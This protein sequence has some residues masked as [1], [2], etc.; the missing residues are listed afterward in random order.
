MKNHLPRYLRQPGDEGYRTPTIEDLEKHG[1]FLLSDGD[2]LTPRCPTPPVLSQ[3]RSRCSQT[4][5]S[6]PSPVVSVQM[7][8][9]DGLP[10]KL[11]WKERIRHLT[12]AFFTLTMAT[13]GLANV[14]YNVPFK[15]RWIE[16][17][18]TTIFLLNIGIYLII[19]ALMCL[20]FYLFP[21][22]FKTSFLHPTESL[23][24]PAVIVSLGTIL[25]NVSQYGP[26]HTGQWL[27]RVTVVLFWFDAVLAVASSACIYLILWSTQM[28]TIA[29]MTPIWIFPAY[30]MLIIGPHA[31]IMSSFASQADSFRIIVG[32]FTIQ[33][34][35]FLVSM[36]VYSAF[37][38]RLMTQKL[39]NEDLRPGMFVSVGPSAFTVVGI[40]GMASH[41]DRA[42]PSDFMGDGELTAKILLVVGSFSAL[43]LWG[44]AVKRANMPFSMAWF[45]FV[46]P[47]TALITST[48]AIGKVFSS[49]ALDIA[50]CV[51]TGLLFLM[52]FFVVFVMFRAIVL[53]QILW[54]QKGEDKDEGGFKIKEIQPNVPNGVAIT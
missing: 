38:Y 40:L 4:P 11:S 47:N 45:S 28:F 48:F 51:M 2:A 7:Q 46:F 25:I 42:I 49:R 19:C 3:F 44:K 53:R 16:V 10:T 41:T 1:A 32:G 39:P 23:F 8:W 20:R 35:G 33:G 24:I 50:G 26:K 12:W 6:L 43:W 52:Y 21:Y 18:G 30:P 27:D 22:T 37:I 14:M 31:A 29:N 5:Q 34:V 54:P 9:T 17:V 13:G 15:A 36:M